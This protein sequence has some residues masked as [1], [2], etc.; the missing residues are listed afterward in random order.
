M[1]L[2]AELFI[3]KVVYN[4]IPEFPESFL[5]FSKDLGNKN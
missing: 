5:T 1:C 3:E 2:Q 4:F